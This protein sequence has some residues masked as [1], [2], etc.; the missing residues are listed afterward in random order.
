MLSHLFQNLPLSASGEFRLQK[1]LKSAIVQKSTIQH[2]QTFVQNHL[3]YRKHGISKP[4][5]ALARTK[6]S[7][8][9]KQSNFC[10]LGEIVVSTPHARP[11]SICLRPLHFPSG[12]HLHLLSLYCCFAQAS[13]PCRLLHA[14]LGLLSSG[15]RWF[16]MAQSSYH[17]WKAQ[18]HGLGE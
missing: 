9:N 14:L 11:D 18:D 1:P 12:H 17:A 3:S 4:K 13:Y 10:A 5:T 6:V 16:T 7:Y 8:N 15:R 2:S